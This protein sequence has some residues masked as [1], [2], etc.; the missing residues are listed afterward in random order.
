MLCLTGS[1]KADISDWETSFDGDVSSSNHLLPSEPL[2]RLTTDKPV[3]WCIE[4]KPNLP[5]LPGSGTGSERH[6]SMKSKSKIHRVDDIPKPIRD[7]SM[8]MAK[9][10][11]G[12]GRE[13]EK[14]QSQS[15]PARAPRN[16]KPAQE[17]HLPPTTAEERKSSAT[18]TD[19]LRHEAGWTRLN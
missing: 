13:L 19:Q 10:A 1:N 9:A 14:L 6:G 7:L 8:G 4:I 15:A 11:E 2:V 16:T 18:S 12:L 5:T 3:M 17:T